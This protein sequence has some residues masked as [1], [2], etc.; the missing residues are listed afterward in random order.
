MTKFCE[1]KKQER[2][3]SLKDVKFAKEKNPKDKDTFG[4]GVLA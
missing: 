1:I 3:S 4:P 2:K